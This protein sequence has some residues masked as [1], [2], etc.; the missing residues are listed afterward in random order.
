MTKLRSSVATAALVAA[1]AFGG[2][3]AAFAAQLD[4][5]EGLDVDLGRGMHGIVYTVA[6]GNG[7]L[8]VVATIDSGVDSTPFRV[9]AV[10]ADGQIVALSTPRQRGSPAVCPNPPDRQQRQGVRHRRAKDGVALC[11][12]PARSKPASPT[13]EEPRQMRWH[14][15]KTLFVLATPLL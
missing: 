3:H 8:H 14:T 13:S 9:D 12:G 1:L 5:L 11:A 6:D 2:G 7:A 10:L 4:P 15:P